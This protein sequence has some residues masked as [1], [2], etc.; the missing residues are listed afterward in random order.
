MSVVSQWCT[1]C[2]APHYRW[3]RP[4]GWWTRYLGPPSYSESCSRRGQIE[5]RKC[6][7]LHDRKTELVQNVRPM[8][9]Q[10]SSTTTGSML[11]G[12][13]Y[14][15]STALF[16]GREW[17]PGT[18]GG[19]RWVLV[20]SLWT[21]IKMIKSPVEASRVTTT[22]KIQGHPHKCRKGYTDI[23][24]WP[25]GA[26]FLQHGTTVNAQHY[27]QTLT[28]LRQVMKL[29]RPG[30]LTRGVILL[31]DSA[32][33]HMANTITALLQKFKWEILGH[34]PYS[35]ALSPCDYANFD[36]LKKLRV[37]Q[38][39]SDNNIKQYVW[40]WFTMQPWECYET[41][42]HCLVSQWDKCLNSQGQYFWHTGT[43]FCS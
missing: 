6:S 38:F 33:P 20:S 40:N 25:R 22:Q 19:W 23:H 3:H 26:P 27:S 15:S 12:P 31:H 4:A 34:P 16:Q 1:F 30:K 11:N 21:R 9:A 42:I 28:T 36:P 2:T 29:K 10:Q 35:P 37:K 7:H 14:W 41:A 18:S 13:L 39:T 5:H 8:G 24:L 17:V 43:G 32:R